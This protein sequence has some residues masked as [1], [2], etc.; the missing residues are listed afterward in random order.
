M[1]G[2]GNAESDTDDEPLLVRVATFQIPRRVTAY[3]LNGD[4]LTYDG[5]QLTEDQGTLPA[6]MSVATLLGI[7]S[8]LKKHQRTSEAEP[9]WI[10][11]GW[12]PRAVVHSDGDLGYGG[13]TIGQFG[14]TI[15][16]LPTPPECPAASST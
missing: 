9:T 11:L 13:D 7:P 4:Q 16:L 8:W 3:S 10:P 15:T 1:E 12:T 5:A 6:H 2:A 14:H